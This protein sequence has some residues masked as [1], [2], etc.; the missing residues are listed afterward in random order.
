[1]SNRQREVGSPDTVHRILIVEDHPVIRQSYVML[2]EREADLEISGEATTAQ[3]AISWLAAAENRLPDLVLVDVS[4]PDMSGI[5]L[6]RQLLVQHP[7]LLML[8]VSGHDDEL[9]AER[10]LG[11][12][13]RGYLNKTKLAEA[14]VPTIRRVLTGGSPPTQ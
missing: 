14:M 2:L 3:Q 4:L 12:G 13:A 8:V 1:M 6:I 10:A 5:N 11:A 7:T 9:Y